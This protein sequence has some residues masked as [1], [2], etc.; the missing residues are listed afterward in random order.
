V[1]VTGG[2]ARHILPRLAAGRFISAF[3]SK[4]THERLTR[5]FPVYAVPSDRLGVL[6]AAR[7]ALAGEGA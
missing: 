3:N 5:E 2:I 7:V 1:Y 4:G 6:G